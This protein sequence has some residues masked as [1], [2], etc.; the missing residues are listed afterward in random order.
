MLPVHLGW[1]LIAR[2]C[3]VFLCCWCDAGAEC[4]ARLV[5]AAGVSIC[6]LIA[7][8]PLSL[9]IYK[10][11]KICSSRPS[12]GDVAVPVPFGMIT[13]GAFICGRCSLPLIPL[14]RLFKRK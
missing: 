2:G 4:R 11:L 7:C 10:D 12:G 9:H 6:T 3:S 14:D 5:A 1:C 8:K 13:I